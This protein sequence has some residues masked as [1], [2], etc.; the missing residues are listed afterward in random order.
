[1]IK[2]KTFLKHSIYL[3]I[4]E[5]VNKN[6]NAVEKYET[7]IGIILDLSKAFDTIDHKILQY[8]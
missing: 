1:M 3:A 7:T 4:A 8:K 6:N 5:L 2:Q